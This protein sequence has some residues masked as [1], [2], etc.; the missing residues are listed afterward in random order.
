MGDPLF[1]APIYDGPP[2]SYYAGTY[3]AAMPYNDPPIGSVTR[4]P[5]DPLPAPSR[6]DS[7]IP[8][9]DQIT[10]PVAKLYIHRLSANCMG[11]W[12]LLREA[13]IPFDLIEVDLT[14][15]DTHTPEFLSMNPMGKVPTYVETD[16]SVIWESNAIMRYI[17]ERHGL[18]DFYPREPN[19]RGRV[20]MALDWRQT[21]LYPNLSKVAYPFLGFSKDR[22]KINEGKNALEKDLKVLTDFFLRETPF[23]GGALPSIAD[24]SIALPLLYL[25]STDYRNPAKV[26][27]YLENLASK[28]PSWNEVTEALKNFMSGMK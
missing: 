14:K 25:Y 7:M 11:P 12:M 2:T 13:G 26:R 23:I 24:Y 15:G 18:A 10:A 28:T 20:E 22:S 8:Y 21:G 9:D 5:Y 27:E 3:G 1:D 16:G 4:I 17:C 6:Y 19:L